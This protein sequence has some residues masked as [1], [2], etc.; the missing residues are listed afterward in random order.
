MDARNEPLKPAVDLGREIT[1]DL[2]AASSREW[3]VTN[4]LGGYAAGT[5]AGVLTRRYHGLL[6]A[7]LKPPVGRT[8]L[9]AKIEETAR[10]AGQDFPLSTNR[11]HDGTIAP[12]GYVNTARFHLEGTIPVWT[13]AFGDGIELEKRVWMRQGANTTCVLY[14]LRGGNQPVEISLKALVNYRDYHG[15]THAGD[16]QMRIEPVAHGLRITARDGATP[17][18]LLS[19][20]AVPD[21]QAE[22]AKHDWYRDFD[23]ALERERGM[24]DCEDHLLAG[25]FRATIAAGGSLAFFATT[26]QDTSLD[27]AGALE[28][29]RARER[30]LLAAWKAAP[31]APALANAPAAPTRQ[32]APAGQAPGGASAP[33]WVRQLVLA[34]D[35]FLVARPSAGEPGACTVIAG[36]PWF[37]DW[38]RDT[39]I[40]LPGLTLATGRPEIAWSILRAY[41]RYIDAGMLPNTFPDGGSPPAY[42]S[43]DAALWYFDAARQTFAATRD[44]GAL[45]QLFPIL[46]GIVDAHV[47]G[48]RYGIRVDSADGL[49]AAGEP[50]VQLTWMDAKIGDRVVTPR[51][52]KPIEVNALW[53]NALV[54]MAGF[55]RA[56]K[57][58]AASYEQM[59]QKARTGFARFW[60]A[61]RGY[62]FDVLDGPAGNEAALRPNQ[63]LAISL[64]VC[65]L[66]LDQQRAVV[67][68]CA[69]ELLAGFALRTLG[70]AE[71]GYRGSYMGPQDERD[72]AYHQGTAW[73]WLLGPFVL[74]HLRVHRNP[75]AAAFYLNPV[76]QHIGSYGLGSVAEICDGDAP[77]APR[78]C[79]AQAWSVAEILR[80]W[81]AV[82]TAR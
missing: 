81:T 45:G 19:D 65:A 12:Q 52:G 57:R 48:T 55:A 41:A 66:S 42:N 31:R 75:A 44:L 43:V 6:V 51:T 34:T 54:T 73:P 10:A 59:A 61:A 3:L 47:R 32:A 35:A 13:F 2:A 25:T 46:A 22:P 38:G 9:V 18:Y 68:V 28:A 67:D 74:A 5:V 39:M 4:G 26:E 58:D 7:A 23:L 29:R 50:G 16:W 21:A 27:A 64:P 11:W 63:L 17:F 72:A 33:A 56:L 49:L 78:G 30:S 62:C 71:P 14:N 8:L 60:N 24:D 36:Y 80:A 82:S 37:S 1:G 79:F 53:M 15:I 76:A 77:F 40:A 70:P 69:R 20:A